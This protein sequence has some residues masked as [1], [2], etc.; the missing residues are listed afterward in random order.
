V[1]LAL[2][3]SASFARLQ[4]N[5]FADFGFNIIDVS[6]RGQ[7]SVPAMRATL[8]NFSGP[9]TTNA[10]TPI[11]ASLLMPRS[12]MIRPCR[13]SERSRSIFLC[14]QQSDFIPAVVSMIFPSP[15]TPS[16]NPLTALPRSDQH[17]QFFVP[18]T[19]TTTTSTISQCQILNEPILLP[20]S[21]ALPNY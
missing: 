1:Q 17:Y 15:L 14:F 16:L 9:M 2:L 18:N 13:K 10:T 21:N 7:S 11:S 5:L 4:L 6:L 12:I 8:G 20:G 19:K 3:L